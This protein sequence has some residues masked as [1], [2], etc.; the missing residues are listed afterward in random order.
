MAVIQWTEAMSVGLTE[1]DE[2]HKLLIKVINQLEANAKD[3]ARHDVVRQCLME[4]Q[5]YAEFHFAREERV[6]TACKF[7]GIGVQKD[8]HRDF[9]DR[10]RDAMARFDS[11]SDAF[12]SVINDELFSYLKEWLSHHILI[13]DMAYRPFVERN[14]AAKEAAKTFRAAEISWRR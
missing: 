1:L 9:I 6:M 11:D 13:E 12:A 5:R 14:A 10:V 3:D 8:E 4:L 2:D 7:P